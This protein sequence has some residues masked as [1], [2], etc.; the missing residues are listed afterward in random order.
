MNANSLIATLESHHLLD[1]CVKSASLIQIE[2]LTQDSRKVVPN[3][4]FIAIKGEKSDGHLFIETAI[5]KGAKLIVCETLPEK[6]HPHV[7]YVQVR[8]V[9][10]AEAILANAFYGFPSKALDMIGITGTNGKTTTT[11]LLHHLLNAIGK[12]AGLIGTIEY[13]IGDKVIESTHTTPDSI[14][15]AAFLKEMQDA[16]CQACV[17]EVSSHALAQERVAGHRFQV[18]VFSNLTHDHLD[19]HHTF[20]DYF[21]AKKKLFDELDENAFALYNID[22]PYGKKM[23]ADTKAK[24]I[25]YGQH[26]EADIRFTVLENKVSGLRLMLD[27][28]ESRFQLVGDFNAYNLCAAYAVGKVL[29]LPQDMLLSVLSQAQPVPGR[30]EQ[31][32]FENDVT[33]IVDYAHTPDALENVLKTIHAVK[34]AHSRIWCVFG[35]G[36]D[37]D[38]AKRAEMGRIAE[39]YADFPIVTSDNPRTEYPEKILRDI[40]LGI[41]HPEK[42]IWILDRHE[43]IEY[44]AENAKPEDVILIAGKGHETYQILGTEKFHFDDRE[45][46]RNA[47]LTLNVTSLN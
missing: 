30:F 42:A 19:F 3:G 25:S 21:L 4:A 8:D 13:K 38:P 31:I 34:D 46:I 12:K 16:E 44:A 32:S 43:A 11:F 35:C 17:M 6:Q 36:G 14:R 24:I 45:Q 33:A 41:Q 26:A 7:H 15:L 18:A 20:E 37:R 28:F 27:G 40:R 10:K 39:H 22:D 23:V 1:K 29:N 47:F 2:G 5:E 9:R